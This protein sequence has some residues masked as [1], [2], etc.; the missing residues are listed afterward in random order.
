MFLAT[1]C[2]VPKADDLLLEPG[3]LLEVDLALEDDLDRSLPASTLNGTI[4]IM[5]LDRR[6]GS[7]PSFGFGGAATRTLACCSWLGTVG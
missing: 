5:K 6:G 4:C 1:C 7:P 3:A 2:K